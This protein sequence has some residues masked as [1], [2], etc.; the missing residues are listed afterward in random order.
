MIVLRMAGKILLLPVWLLLATAHLLVKIAVEIYC[1]GKGIINLI[2]GFMLI[3]TLLW[4]RQW[5]RFAL[6]AVA[7][8]ILLFFLWLIINLVS[9]EYSKCIEKYLSD[10]DK[11]ITVT[12]C[13]QSGDKLVTKGTYAKMARGEM[14]RYMAEK[15]IENPADVQTFDRLGYNFRRDLSSEIEYVFERKIME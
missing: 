12:F 15:E 1:I 8:G 2:L 6:L 4:Y 14:V 11:Y 3:G 13:E 10:K 5:E 7:G 9:K